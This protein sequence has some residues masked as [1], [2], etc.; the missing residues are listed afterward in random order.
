MRHARKHGTRDD[1]H[2]MT[3]VPNPEMFQGAPSHTTFFCATCRLFFPV[4]LQKVFVENK[5]PAPHSLVT[6]PRFPF[7]LAFN[8]RV[9]NNIIL[10]Y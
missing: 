10:M 6:Y 8:P 3:Q 9:L 1:G 4:V 2:D 5:L 7:L